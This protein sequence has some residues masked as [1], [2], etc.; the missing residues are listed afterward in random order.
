MGKGS[1]LEEFYFPYDRIRDIQKELI[2]KIDEVISKKGRLIV[3]APTGLG[4]TVASL[5]PALRYALKRDLTVF[6]LTSRHTQHFIAIDTLKEI[7]EKYNLQVIATDIIG[8]KW[9]CPVPGVDGLYSGDF[10]D[11]CNSVREEGKCEFYLNTKKG[12][13]LTKEAELVLTQIKELSPCHSERVIELC[14]EYRLCPYEIA[15]ELAKISKVIIADYYYV[16]HPDIRSLFFK[17]AEKKLEA[18]IIIVDEG[19]NLPSRLR[20]LLSEKLSSFMIDSAV[21]EAKKFSYDETG[22]N[23]RN[24]GRALGV[25]G[26]KITEHEECLITKTEFV[27]EV[28]RFGNYDELVADFKFIGEAVREADKRSFIGSIA[29]FMETWQ[30]EDKGFVR[31]LGRKGGRGGGGGRGDREVITLSYRCLDPSIVSKE[32]ISTA[33]SMVMMSGTLSP[34]EMYKDILGFGDAELAEFESPFPKENRLNLIIPMTTTKFSE[35][36]EAQYKKIAEV[37]AELTNMIPGNMILFFPSY[38]IRDRVNRHFATLCRKSTFTEQPNLNKDEK[39]ELL[40]RF[41]NYKDSGAVLLAAVSGSFGEGIDLPGDYLNAVVVIGLPLSVPDFETK[42]LIRYYDELFSKGWDYG[43]VFP[44][45][46]KVMQNAGR[47][48]RSETDRGATIFLDERYSWHQYSR[49]FPKEWDLVTTVLYKK[50]LEE[51]FVK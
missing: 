51:F 20:N 8:K 22:S 18:S 28:E 30:G 39:K 44:A 42:A 43:Y 36:S 37:C 12:T 5:C 2:L 16:F 49:C 35:R 38:D 19:H 15:T 25:L 33:N 14:R 1:E 41:K 47:V 32:V 7:K 4:K 34:L 24:L 48:I 17:K 29:T 11:Y 23:L 31:I 3:H 46:N 13:K 50:K 9:M 21:R 6:F 27:K 45:M 26:E 10:A 40:E